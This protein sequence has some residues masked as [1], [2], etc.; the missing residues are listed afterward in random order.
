[1]H[2]EYAY[3]NEGYGRINVKHN[4]LQQL[5]NKA[6]VKQKESDPF[7]AVPK[8]FHKFLNTTSVFAY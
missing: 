4:T 3:A 7:K 8:K 1:M 6:E 2:K 5:Y